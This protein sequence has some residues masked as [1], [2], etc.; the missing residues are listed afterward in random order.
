MLLFAR[1]YFGGL[2]ELEAESGSRECAAATATAIA[3][4]EVGRA[5]VEERLEYYVRVD[6]WK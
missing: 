4:I 6:I 2:A 1:L 3:E 5:A